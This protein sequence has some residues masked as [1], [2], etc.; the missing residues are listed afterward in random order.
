M[1][2]KYRDTHSVQFKKNL[3]FIP[4][5]GLS[6]TLVTTLFLAWF[7]LLSVTSVEQTLLKCRRKSVLFMT[8]SLAPCMVLAH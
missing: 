8:V 7:H 6:S 4:R 5:D 1:S 3:L 2:E